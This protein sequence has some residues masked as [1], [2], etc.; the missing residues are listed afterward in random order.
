MQTSSS[1]S[2]IVTDVIRLNVIRLND[3]TKERA[4]IWETT[5]GHMRA[6]TLKHYNYIFREEP[7]GK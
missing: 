6:S 7:R 2:E 3:P 4:F 1:L 5:Y